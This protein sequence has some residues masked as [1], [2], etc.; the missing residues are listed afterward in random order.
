MC[1]PAAT[2]AERVG[3][4]ALSCGGHLGGEYLAAGRL[5]RSPIIDERA[6]EAEHDLAGCRG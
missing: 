6:L 3:L 1:A 4:D 2:W 5:M